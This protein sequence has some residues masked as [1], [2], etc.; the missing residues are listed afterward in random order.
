MHVTPGKLSFNDTV[1][2]APA[3]ITLQND[4]TSPVTYQLRNIP[5]IAIEPYNMQLQGF[6]PLE[7]SAISTTN[8]SAELRFDVE[9]ITL[10]P[11]ERRTVSVAVERL[12]NYDDAD[13]HPFP[14]YGGYIALV[15]EDGAKSLHVPYIGVEGE[16]AK[17][18]M[19]D[20][21]FPVAVN[22]EAL[23]TQNASLEQTYTLDRNDVTGVNSVIYIVYRL[24]TGTAELRT[25][26]LDASHE[27]IGT[28]LPTKYLQRNNIG[29][30]NWMT[31]DTWNGTYVPNGQDGTQSQVPVPSGTY[32][33]RWSALRLMSDPDDPASWETFESVPIIV[34]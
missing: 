34:V 6:A 9:Q 30:D 24:L 11:G 23:Q 21:G 15:A 8:L 20:R 17:L 12:I 18:P 25:D 5:A 16:M 3:V 1:H 32:T 27:K 14:V 26:V 31:V 28:L 19:F 13:V 7:P 10:Q 4:D 22:Q 33:L 29:T 2:R